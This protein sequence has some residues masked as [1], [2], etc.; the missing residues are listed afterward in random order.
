MFNKH[1]KMKNAFMLKGKFAKCGYDWWWHSFTGIDEETKEEKAFFIEFYLTNPKV[2]P[3]KVTYG[4][5]GEIPSYLMIKCGAWGS[6]HAQLHK[7]IP[8][9]EANINKKGPIRIESGDFLLTENSLKGNV[10]ITKEEALAHPE[11]MSDYGS[12]SFDLKIEKQIPFNVGYGTSKFFRDIHA[13]EMYWHAEGMKS[14]YE[15]T[16]IF[17]G[18]KYNITYRRGSWRDDSV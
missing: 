9:S 5:L 17:N 4:R 1:N 13:F 6:D 12:M 18:R 7:F 16:V 8:W 2:S 10:D 15:G 11:Y 14:K 3:N